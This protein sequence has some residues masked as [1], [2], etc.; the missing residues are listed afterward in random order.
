MYQKHY[1]QSLS[2]FPS[3]SGISHYPAFPS[4]VPAPVP[5]PHSVQFQSVPFP[6][7]VSV[8]PSL[9]SFLSLSSFI[10][11]HIFFPRSLPFPISLPFSHLFPFIIPSLLSSLPFYH[12][13]LRTLPFPR[14]P[15][16]IVQSLFSSHSLFLFQ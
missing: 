10:T 15:P 6:R 2:L 5:F 14:T 1:P 3:L 8:F 7:S 9:S 12:S 13:L 4:S 16:F 11:N